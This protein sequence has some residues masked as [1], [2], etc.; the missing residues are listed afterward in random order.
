MNKKIV[1]YQKMLLYCHKNCLYCNKA[2]TD[3]INNCETCIDG[4][5]FIYNH[6]G[7]CIKEG[8]QPDD[9][10]LDNCTDT[11]RKCHERCSKCVTAGSSIYHNCKECAKY[12]NGTYIYHFVYTQAEVCINDSEK[13]SNT[14]LDNET[15]TYEKCYTT[16]ATCS[17]KGNS[18]TNNCDSCANGYH[19]IYNQTGQCIKE[20]EQPDDTYYEE[21]EDKYEKCYD[22]CSKCNGKGDSTSHNCITCAEGFHLVYNQP[23]IC[24]PD[25][26]QPNGTYYD[27]DTDT[28]KEC[29]YTCSKC[30]YGGT[31][32]NHNC[33]ECAKYENGTYK[34]HFIYTK[35]GQCVGDEEKCSNC[36]LDEEDNEYEK[37]YDKCSECEH[38]GNKTSQNCSGCVEG[39]HF[40]YNLPGVC[41][42]DGSQ[43]DDTYLDNDTY[44]PC[45]E[46]CEKCSKA[47]DS[48]NHNCDMCK[49]DENGNY[50][51]HFIYNKPGQ[52]ITE[53][54][55]PDNTTLDKD[56]NTYKECH[57][58]CQRQQDLHHLP[59]P[60]DQPEPDLHDRTAAHG[61]DPAAHGQKQGAVLGKGGGNAPPRKRK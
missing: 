1:F 36:Y 50:I 19:F 30:N 42:P 40:I 47:G 56:D 17:N 21:E 41:I 33:T 22:K 3:E 48:T 29:Y 31:A 13:P 37:C 45:Y 5:H 46:R 34:Y 18:T 54:E 43:P 2:G 23:G 32:S 58:R 53:D 44:K 60:H 26:E 51:Y 59:G 57:E 55:K 16:C 4:Y 49:Q 28:Y 9:T 39:Y 52:C 38:K 14:Y 61:S 11:Y 7:Q 8:T 35:E 12:E 15:N 10:Y 27:N 20:G 24:I 25:S 6:T